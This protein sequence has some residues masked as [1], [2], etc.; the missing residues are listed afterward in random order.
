M[1]P[2]KASH[3]SRPC[4]VLYIRGRWL[5]AVLAQK[6]SV[7]LEGNDV[8]YNK[9]PEATRMI[10]VHFMH[11]YLC[12][13]VCMYV[14]M[15]V[16]VCMCVY[17]CIHI[18]VRLYV[19][20]YA[21]VHDCR[22]VC[23]RMFVCMYV[24]MHVYVSMFVCMH[25]CMYAYACMVYVYMYASTCMHVCMYV[26]IHIYV[27]IEQLRLA[28]GSRVGGL[29]VQALRV[30]RVKKRLH[31]YILTNNVHMISLSGTKNYY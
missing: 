22:Y 8:L 1:D 28:Q 23:T 27:C 14:Y 29:Y 25:A 5:S 9:S 3:V 15:Y 16:C 2:C 19:C 26:S 12:M 20:V 30:Q 17:V 6:Y 31:S 21:C 7:C 18:H 4:C 13:Y 11:M 10:T 24:C